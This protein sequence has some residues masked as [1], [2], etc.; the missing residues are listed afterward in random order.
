ML[1]ADPGAALTETRRV[2]RDG[3]RLAFVVWNTP[4]R[5]LWAAG[6]AKTLVQRGHLPSP[7][8]GMPGMF[9]VGDPGRIRELVAGAGFAEPEL[10]EIAFDFDYAGSDDFWDA[11]VSL[12]G[13]LARAAILDS[14]ESYRREDG[15]YS[16]PASAWGVLAA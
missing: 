4:D 11:L 6:P 2:L 3:G 5:N 1:M 16:V 14:V 7:E 8:P 13:P 15:S 12:A 9:T 10:E